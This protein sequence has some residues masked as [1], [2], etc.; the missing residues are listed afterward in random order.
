MAFDAARYKQ[1]EREAY[2]QVAEAWTAHVAEHTALYSRRLLELLKPAEGAALLDLA[3]GSGH[4]AVDAATRFRCRVSALDLSEKMLH[5]ARRLAAGVDAIA[6]HLGDAEAL[7]F[8]DGA[9]D[10]VACSLGL[11]YFPDTARALD[12]IRRVLRPEGRTGFVVWPLPHST[13]CLRVAIAATAEA[14][15]QG[16]LG[17]LIR[18][19]RVGEWLLFRRIEEHVP[20]RGPSPF[21][22]GRRGKLARL[23]ERA[24]FR[25]VEIFEDTFVWRY[26]S[27]DN[28]WHSFARATPPPPGQGRLSREAAAEIR[29]RME[30]K[31]APWRDP[32]RELAFP[33]T[34]LM[35]K[36][37]R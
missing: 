24:G 2:D 29:R 35:V 20:G 28:F 12:E 13:P 16:P 14:T 18:L 8:P 37:E 32:W 11:M 5:E 27:F 22:F 1:Y 6:F 31:A 7:P 15:V 30:R 34:A 23:L 36:A 26:T 33:M 3:C 17:A 4:L 25:S 9:F 19:P 21:R 10:V